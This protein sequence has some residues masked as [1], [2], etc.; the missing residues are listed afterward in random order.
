MTLGHIRGTLLEGA[1]HGGSLH[2]MSR[3]VSLPG[4]RMDEE[5]T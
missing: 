3:H 5:K 4:S 2:G 1:V